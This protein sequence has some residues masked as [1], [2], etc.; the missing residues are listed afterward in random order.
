VLSRAE[1]NPLFLEELLGTLIERGALRE[2]EWEQAPAV[3]ETIVP[4]TVHAVLAA[5]I[6]LLPAPEKGALQA[7]SVIG[8]AFW[9]GAVRA[10]S[11]G[12]EPDLR[13]LQQRDFVRRSSGSSLEDEREFVF[14]HAL[15][16]EVA[17]GSLTRRERALKHADFAAWLERRGGGR[18]E[19]A[20]LLAHHYAEAVR[21]EDADLVWGDES[22]RYEQTRALAARWLRRAAELAAGRYEI[23]DALALLD[24]ALGLGP[25]NPRKIE[26]LRERGRVHMLRY[27]VHGFRAAMD[28]AL[29]MGPDRA[30]AAEIYAQLAYYAC[31]RPYLWKEPPPPEVGEDWLAKALGLSEPDSRARAWALLAQALSEPSTRQEAAAKA[32][33]LGAALGE[34]TLVVLASEAQSLGA[35]EAR[36][37]QEARDRVD[38][39]VSRASEVADP[40]FRSHVY[41]NAG[42]VYV[43]AGRIPGAR[44][45]AEQFDR[46]A[47]SLTAHDRVHAVGLQSAIESVGGDWRA[48]AE[49]TARVERA[50]A[51]NQD[52]PCQFNW[53]TLLVCALAHAQ[54]GDERESRRLEESGRA[55]A[56]VAGPPELEPALLRLALL[57]GDEDEAR[58]ILGLLPAT[59]DAFGVDA[60]AARLD[61]LLALHE[62]ERLEEEAAPFLTEEGYTRPFAL[63]AVG[64]ARG[65]AALVDEA[66]AGFGAIGLEWRAAETRALAA[67][68]AT[69]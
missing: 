52:F 44:R 17:Y 57:R 64:L 69:R 21:P 45:F 27:D 33:R 26:I 31:G 16:R 23:D 13:V 62:T 4:D 35:T 40:G 56:V 3:G 10:L 19:D 20:P 7:A 48:L 42:F 39:A 41:W 14:K 12:E 55:G 32:Y 68:A 22:E 34:P 8:R 36:R 25:E 2:G 61:A 47:S 50:S 65:D 54:L 11:G 30:A 59:G 37:Y 51:A 43:R 67:A 53:R 29:A 58:R 60:A 38:E 1:G 15:T 5:R 9:P 63:R 24:R 6:D 46:L 49:L 28:E 66:A 18:H